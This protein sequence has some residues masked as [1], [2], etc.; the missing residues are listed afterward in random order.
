MRWEVTMRRVLIE[1]TELEVT[2]ETEDDACE[3]AVALYT[4]GTDTEGNDLGWYEVD[5]DE[6][7]IV[8]VRFCRQVGEE[9]GEE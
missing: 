7:R 6:D 5:D 1:E 3:L 8:Q 2:A 9:G 4:S